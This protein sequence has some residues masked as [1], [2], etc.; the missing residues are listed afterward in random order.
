MFKYLLEIQF[1]AITNRDKLVPGGYVTVFKDK[2]TD[3]NV[4]ISHSTPNGDGTYRSVIKPYFEREQL[5][6][7]KDDEV[8]YKSIGFLVIPNNQYGGTEDYV[9][10]IYINY[11]KFSE[12]MLIV[13]GEDE[14]GQGIQFGCSLQNHLYCLLENKENYES[15]VI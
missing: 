8:Y 1:D 6:T 2:Q 3:L 15:K 14:T 10:Q 4:L 13:F 11:N 5:K 12:P 9:N 7:L